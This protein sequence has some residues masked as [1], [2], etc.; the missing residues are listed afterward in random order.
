MANVPQQV[1]DQGGQ[2]TGLY[3]KDGA[4]YKYDPQQ[5]YVQTQAPQATNPGQTT[6]NPTPATP[7]Q[8]TLGTSRNPSTS[9]QQLVQQ[10]FGSTPTAYQSKFDTGFENLGQTGHANPNVVI[11]GTQA[12]ADSF[13]TKYLAKTGKLPD[14]STV[15]SFVAQ[16][17]TPSFAQ[18]FIQGIPGDQIDLISDNYIKGNP[19]ILGG[20]N[21]DQDQLN[22]L[23]NS[24][25][26]AYKAGEQG[27]VSSYMND[28]YAPT[29]TRTA[30]DL[31]GQGMLTNANS[32]YALNNVESNKSRDITS[33][34]N[35]LAG[36]KASG[37]ID[38]AKTIANLIQGNKDRAQS[39]YQF[40]QQFNA[41]QD[42][43]A[44]NQGLQRKQLSIAEQ[45]GRMQAGNQSN[46]GIF[47]ALG[48]GLSGAGSGFLSGSLAG[49][50]ISP[51]Y[52][53]LIGGGLGLLGGY[54]GSK[55]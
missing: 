4:Y 21:S 9:A 15:R 34:L 51:G 1:L 39:G 11:A 46:D 10:I 42:N 36:N 16:N 7:A 49:S 33:G 2:P 37:Q 30:D 45:I 20:N 5:G 26:D 29:K 44:F 55:K 14:E 50:K 48:G 24:F 22:N 28:V 6:S 12:L 25:N 23:Q 53:T 31:A 27:L 43:T 40:Q 54:F 35:V 3:F 8:A 19:D 38:I 32:R 41:N 13:A 18:N 47:G 17:L 52:G